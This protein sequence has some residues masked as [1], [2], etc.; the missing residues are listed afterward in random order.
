MEAPNATI[1]KLPVFI[2]ITGAT[3]TRLGENTMTTIQ[4]AIRAPNK[5]VKSFVPVLN[6]PAIEKNFMG[7]VGFIVP[8]GI[9]NKNEF[10]GHANI[11]TTHTDREAGAESQVLGKSLLLIKHTIPVHILKNLNAVSLVGTMGFPG[12]IIVILQGPKTSPK[13][14]TK[15]NGFPDVGL[16]HEGLDLKTFQNL[17]VGDGFIRLEKGCVAGLNRT[18][19][20]D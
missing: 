1:N 20:R 3:Y 15:S 6:T 11:D 13:I 18:K 9:G 4:P 5:T 14:K 2:L 10:G 12:L 17:H 19:S 16:R 8:I 7:T